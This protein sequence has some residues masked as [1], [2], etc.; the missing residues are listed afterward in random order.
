MCKRNFSFCSLIIDFNCLISSSLFI[1]FVLIYMQL[2][3]AA[4]RCYSKLFA[5]PKYN[6]CKTKTYKTHA[7]ST[8][9]MVVSCFK[10]P[11]NRVLHENKTLY[12]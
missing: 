3:L 11:N 7:N 9:P 1:M 5:K 4:T 2:L 10:H 6:S 8:K 12:E